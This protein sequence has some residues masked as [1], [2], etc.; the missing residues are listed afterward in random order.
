M[1]SI[2]NGKDGYDSIKE[3]ADRTKK[4][5]QDKNGVLFKRD[6]QPPQDEIAWVASKLKGHRKVFEIGFGLGIW[7]PLAMTL[8]CDYTGIEPV[9]QRVS[10]A[11]EHYPMGNFILG[12]A[13]TARVEGGEEA[14]DAVFTVTV[15]QHMGL[16]D[17]IDLLKTAVWHLRPGGTLIMMESMILNESVAECERRYADKSCS[18]HMVPKPIS[19]LKKAVRDFKWVQEG[20]DRFV[21]TKQGG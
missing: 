9:E 1:S 4:E 18:M 21:L 3:F 12:D 20:S 15:I 17:A 8:G 7:A 13:R 16:Q 2:L 14:F 5:L 11:L 19:L 6:T 10:Y